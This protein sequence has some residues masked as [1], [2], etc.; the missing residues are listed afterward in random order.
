VAV[1]L[2]HVQAFAF[3]GIALPFLLLTTPAVEGPKLMPRRYALAGVVPGVVLFILWVGVRVGAPAEIAPGQPW[4]SWGPMLSEQ[5]LSWKTF[6][7]NWHDMVPFTLGQLLDARPVGAGVLAGMLRDGS[8]AVG[9]ALAIGVAVV[10]L[11]IA[12][13][14]RLRRAENRNYALA[15]AGGA[16]AAFIRSSRTTD[17]HES[18]LLLLLGVGLLLVAVAD[19][20]P[21]AAPPKWVPQALRDAWPYLLIVVPAVTFFLVPADATA[22]RAV[23]VAGVLLAVSRPGPE[24]LLAR[25]RMPG[26]LALALVGLFALPFDIRGYMYYLNTRYAHLAAALAV[27]CVPPLA[28][29]RLVR[30]LLAAAMIAVAWGGVTLAKGFSAFDVE[31]Q[32]LQALT[33]YTAQK[34]RVMGLIYNPGS[35]TMTHPVFL[36]ASTVLARARGGVTNFS[37]ALTPHSPL[38]Y[39]GN[40]PPTFPSEW[41]PDQMDWASQ[42]A[43]YDHFV[44][45][46]PDPR[47]IFGS[48]LDSELMVAAQS[49]SFFLVRKR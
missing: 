49:G 17:L 5:N 29:K 10:A 20:G 23:A 46:G 34:P 43:W 9:V 36:H 37:F 44:V 33:Q 12:V 42:G 48:K 47:Q 6:E 39:R 14:L 27:C 26:L 1:L 32:Q 15:V 28:D 31:S 4:K 13:G 21:A 40:P 35:A 18:V 19:E 8:D 41:R 16:I 38:M 24:G 30:G 2:M 11:I 3:L 7:Q 45:R 25:W 22:V